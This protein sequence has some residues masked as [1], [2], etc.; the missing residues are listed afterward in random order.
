[1]PYAEPLT[2]EEIDRALATLD[3]WSREADTI[4]RTV[5]CADFR[6]AIALV[7]AVADAAEAADHHPDIELRRYKRVTFILTTHA[8]KAI[9][10]RDIELA[11]EIDRLAA[12]IGAA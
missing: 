11:A 9:T 1:M 3:G 10:R 6:A 2:D 4:R 12:R 8:A 7:D 5:V